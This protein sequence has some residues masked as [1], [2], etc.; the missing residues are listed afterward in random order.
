MTHR[1][2][3]Y[4]IDDE[5]DICDILSRE[6]GAYGF[7]VKTFLTGAQLKEA[8]REQSPDLCIVDLGLPD[9]DGIELVKSLCDQTAM[10]VMILSGRDSVTD[11]ILGLELG[12]DDYIVKPFIP[13]ELIARV[14]SLFRRLR[15]NNHD[16]EVAASAVAQFAGWRYDPS[17]LTLSPLGETPADAAET[18][19][20]SSAE[21]ELLMLLLH[22]P[23]KILSRDQLLGERVSPFDRS[24]D[25]RMSRVRK[26]LENSP[27]QPTLIKTVYGVGYI[28]TA[29]VVWI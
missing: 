26:K 16:I 18:N 17:T 29:D 4:I 7:E 10:G 23:K 9:M 28:L 2:L 21:H 25:V 1:K 13:R 12:A 11:R 8:L 15:K 14:N 3:I 22:S 20:L 5:R 19:E 6:L 27:K 24:I